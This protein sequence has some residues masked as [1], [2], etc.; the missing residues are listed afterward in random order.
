MKIF[1]LEKKKINRNFIIHL[2]VF[3]LTIFYII[4]YRN[5]TDGLLL[6]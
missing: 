2:T 5:S 3:I 1:Q 4:N 6:F